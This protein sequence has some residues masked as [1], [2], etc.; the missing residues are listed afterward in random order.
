MLKRSKM[1]KELEIFS[2]VEVTKP[3][4]PKFECPLP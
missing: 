3:R 4:A 2:L 1:W